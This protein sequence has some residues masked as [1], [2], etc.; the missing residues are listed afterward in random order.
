MNDS[1]LISKQLYSFYSP[2]KTNKSL[3]NIYR[4]VTNDYREIKNIR[5][6]FNNLI[7]FNYLNETVIKSAFIQRHL[8]KK[9]PRLNT[10][11]LELNI[12]NSRADLCLINGFSYVY[13]IKTEYDSF[14]RLEKQLSDYKEVFDYIY[15]IVPEENINIVK[16]NVS[17]EI[18]IISYKLNRLNNIVFTTVK[19][20]ILNNNI[21]SKTQLNS[22]T[23]QELN[24]LIKTTNLSKEGLVKNLL[25]NYNKDQINDF[26]RKTVKNKYHKRWMFLHN[27]I[28]NIYLLDYQW[29][30]KNNIDYKKVYN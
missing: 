11:I 24:K 2:L 15:V 10:A 9:S 21:N 25:D 16:S 7:R 3:L 1:L 4:S 27:N 29:F 19:E 8:S 6:K 20:A 26:Y 23:K 14:S 18:G 13:E 30:F 12:A 28:D 22:L 5:A 17:K